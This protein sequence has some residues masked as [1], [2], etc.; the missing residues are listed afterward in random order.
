MGWRTAQHRS[1]FFFMEKNV[2]T[3]TTWIAD[4]ANGEVAASFNKP[5]KSV[6]PSC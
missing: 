6:C 4:S 5:V 3:P 1:V 2:V